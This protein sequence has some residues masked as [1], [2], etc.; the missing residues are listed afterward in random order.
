MNLFRQMKGFGLGL[1]SGYKVYTLIKIHQAVPLKWLH[2]ITLHMYFKL[3]S[4]GKLIYQ[5]HLFHECS[6][7][8][9]RYILPMPCKYFR[10]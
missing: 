5:K 2:L 1:C 4:I 8:S 6:H 10:E 3:Q 9:Y 7:T